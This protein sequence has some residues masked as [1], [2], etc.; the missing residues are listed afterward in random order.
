MEPLAAGLPTLVGPFHSNNREALHFQN[1]RLKT[2][3]FSK[4]KSLSIVTVIRD[5]DELKNK[6][7]FLLNEHGKWPEQWPIVKQ[8]IQQKISEKTGATK[9]LMEQIE[10]LSL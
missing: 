8:E 3:N 2:A 6:L 7:Q 4:G 1:I 9:K 5:S 10:A